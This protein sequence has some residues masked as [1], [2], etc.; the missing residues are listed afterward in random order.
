[1]GIP[2]IPTFAATRTFSWLSNGHWGAK[3]HNGG[4]PSAAEQ[5]SLNGFA[6]F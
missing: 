1:M 4:S 5:K 6:I 3:G 2:A